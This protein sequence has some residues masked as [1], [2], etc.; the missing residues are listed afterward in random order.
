MGTLNSPS[1]VVNNSMPSQHR[2]LRCINF[3][4]GESSPYLFLNMSNLYLVKFE[5]WWILNE[6]AFY[7]FIILFYL[8]VNLDLEKTNQLGKS[9]PIFIFTAVNLDPIVIEKR[10]T[11]GESWPNYFDEKVNRGE[12]LRW[13]GSRCSLMHA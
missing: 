5:A 8:K 13:V 6:Q 1:R 3:G 2:I 7:C 11:D 9:S 4:I 12:D 10:W